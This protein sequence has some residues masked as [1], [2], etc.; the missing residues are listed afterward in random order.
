MSKV[1]K[2]LLLQMARWDRSRST[3]AKTSMAFSHWPPNGRTWVP[4]PD[5]EA[6]QE[7]WNERH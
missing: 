3:I 2:M 6:A 5:T 7:R 1:F 4:S